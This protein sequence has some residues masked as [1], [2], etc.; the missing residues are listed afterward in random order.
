VTGH[1][2]SAVIGI[3]SRTDET[4]VVEEFFQLFKTPWEMYRPGESYD[5]I[6]VTGEEI[7][8]AG[9]QLVLVFGAGQKKWDQQ[10]NLTARACRQNARIEHHGTQFPLYGKVLTFE[11][12]EHRVVCRTSDSGI[13]GV[14]TSHGSSRLWRIG[15]DLFQE[16]AFLLSSGQPVENAGVPTLELHIALLRDLILDAGIPLLEIPPSPAGY[17]FSVCLTHDIDFAGIRRHKFDHTMWGFL[18]RA[19]LGAARDALTR[20]IRFARMFQAWK[21]AASLPFVFLGWSRDFWVMFD[22]YM[23]VEK[24]LSPTYFFIPFKR[25]AGDKVPA[26]NPSRRAS[27]YDIG[28]VAEWTDRLQA[29]GCEVGVHG[30]DAWH[31]VEKGREELQR[32]AAVTGCSGMGIRMHW[33]LRDE[34]TWRIL[35][36][37]GYSY[38]STAGYNETPGYRNGT[39]QTFRPLTTR[40]LLELPMHIQDGALFFSKRLGLSEHEAWRSC[41]KFIANVKRLGGVLT[42]LWH[43]RSPGPERFWGDFYIKLV[44]NLK[45]HHV[46]FGSAGQVVSWFRQRREIKFERTEDGRGMR[47]IKLH[48]LGKRIEPPLTVRIT[49]AAAIV[50]GDSARKVIEHS[51]DGESDIEIG[52]P[53]GIVTGAPEETLSVSLQE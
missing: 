30:I 47:R 7:P 6:L 28:D 8:E 23:K 44:Q 24:G 16:I 31:S 51:W 1:H 22:W 10:A 50:S 19:T 32:V 27:A 42:V 35:E 33:L 18:F 15:Y 21:A 48:A 45:S 53:G 11:D 40:K 20:K 46:W 14:E 17:D 29:E 26:C 49:S 13:A 38:D 5:V 41:E 3:V 25:R 39:T 36:E 52:L 43:D 34:N 2:F 4:G 12:S 9:A 37:A